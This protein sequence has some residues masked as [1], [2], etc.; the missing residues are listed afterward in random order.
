MQ[1]RVEGTVEKLPGEE[2][3]AYYH[4]RPRGSQIGAH[5]SP[6]STVLRG[7][8]G[9]LEDRNAQL[10]QV[11]LRSTA[12]AILAVNHLK[13]DLQMAEIMAPALRNRIRAP[14]RCGV[15]MKG[16]HS[17]PRDADCAEEPPKG[18][19]SLSGA[20]MERT[21]HSS[22]CS[23]YACGAE[24]G[25]SQ[26]SCTCI[27]CSGFLNHTERKK[28]AIGMCVLVIQLCS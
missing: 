6:Q 28:A 2:S 15:I 22:V 10:K 20:L 17:G 7:G 8:R 25:I 12:Y 27:K 21:A 9:S 5:V 13:C 18:P 24:Q 26:A 3:D 16:Y 19:D 23:Q 11:G 1:V 14:E 4:S